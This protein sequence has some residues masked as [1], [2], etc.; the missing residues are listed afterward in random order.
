MDTDR[1]LIADLS[2]RL[3]G[4]A[5]AAASLLRRAGDSRGAELLA[6]ELERASGRDFL[7]LVFVG[8]Y[9]AGKSTIIRA[10]TGDRGIIVDSDVA[11]D[12]ATEYM[13]HGI[14]LVDTPGILAG[15]DEA[16]DRRALEAMR[17]S[18]LVVY[19]VT[20][21][22]FDEAS[23]DN[24][25]ATAFDG[26]MA[27]KIMFVIN[28][29]NTEYGDRQ[30]LRR[31]YL[32]SLDAM[33]R[34]RGYE[35]FPFDP[36]CVDAGDYLEGLEGN[37]RE[38]IEISGFDAFI[39]RL[40]GFV[41]KE[42]LLRKRLDTPARLIAGALDDMVLANVDPSLAGFYRQYEVRL[43]RALTEMDGR[44]KMILNSFTAKSMGLVVDL[45]KKIGGVSREQWDRDELRLSLALN[46]LADETS[47][48]IESMIDE[49]YSR[50]MDDLED[51]SGKDSLRRY[52]LDLHARIESPGLDLQE[53]KTLEIVQKGVDWLTRN[54]GRLAGDSPEV[55]KILEKL[56]RSAGNDMHKHL[57]DIV[58][59]FG[60]RFKPWGGSGV[61]AK[62]GK[63]AKA[64]LPVVLALFDIGMQIRSDIDD[65]RMQ[66]RV[67][68]A[69]N[70]YVEAYRRRIEEACD[71]F[72]E[73]F[74]G[75]AGNFALK[76]EELDRQRHELSSVL[77]RNGEIARERRQ[78][79]EE[80]GRFIA[81][82]SAD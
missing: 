72:R 69:R 79:R 25:V 43:R 32:R 54:A 45:S 9:N 29:M 4:L 67:A 75:V 70:G 38:L 77:E 42:G 61:A 39:G 27:G 59:F 60:S 35:G 22:L 81:D 20:P 44:L 17:R 16:H 40:N 82:L 31:N 15:G 73:A 19:V 47:T 3:A 63:G 68:A 48:E 62:I 55:K 36:V 46:A 64:G 23:F 66:E 18:D 57:I 58:G 37:D 8:Q 24:F 1:L 65:R 34:E 51:F 33:F 28:K 53:K 50:L 5:D 11:T 21:A 6:D 26:H 76:H 78:L 14:A 80:V 49:H 13:W 52:A 56:G 12:V 30:E 7:S 10:L 74:R 41:A 71:G 2:A